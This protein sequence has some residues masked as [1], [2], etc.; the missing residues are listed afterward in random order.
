[1]LAANEEDL[2]AASEKLRLIMAKTVSEAAFTFSSTVH[3]FRTGLLYVTIYIAS[4][5]IGTPE[6]LY[7]S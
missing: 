3:T 2:K 7:S 1:M 4:V 6:C 5:C